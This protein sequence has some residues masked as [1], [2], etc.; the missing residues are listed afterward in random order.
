ME[1][2]IKISFWLAVFA[3]ICRFAT[4]AVCDFPHKRESSLGGYLVTT[5]II[6][7]EA[8]WIGILLWNN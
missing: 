2:Y 1:L 7:G 4:L 5:L 3:I 6:I 8:V